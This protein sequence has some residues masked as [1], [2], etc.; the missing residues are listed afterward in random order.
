[1]RSQPGKREDGDKKR[2][3]FLNRVPCHQGGKEDGMFWELAGESEQVRW[4]VRQQE[5][6][7]RYKSGAVHSRLGHQR[8]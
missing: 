7:I 2:K 6:I 5:Q 3:S 1:M 4:G 8:L